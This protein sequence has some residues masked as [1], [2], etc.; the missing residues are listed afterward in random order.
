MWHGWQGRPTELT[1]QKCTD[2]FASA[3]LALA[4]TFLLRVLPRGSPPAP[5]PL[6]LQVPSS[7]LPQ[8]WLEILRGGDDSACACA[9]SGHLTQTALDTATAAASSAEPGR[10]LPAPSTSSRPSAG[11]GST[12]TRSAVQGGSSSGSF[13]LGTEL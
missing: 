6:L 10:H 2:L 9:S 5:A 7:P 1:E 11:A 3:S 12:P 8:P 4:P 13:L